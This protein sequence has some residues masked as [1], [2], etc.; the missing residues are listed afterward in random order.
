MKAEVLAVG[1][2]LLLGD[3]INTNAAEIS[4]ALAEIGV[5]VYHQSVVG[6][7]EERLAG[8]F[9]TGLA[10]SDL[11]VVCGGLGPTE[12]DLTRETLARVTG[13]DLKRNEAWAEHL[14]EIFAKRRWGKGPN[15]ELPENN[16]RQTMV[17]D[18]ATLLENTR[19]T[20]PGIYLRYNNTEVFLLP[21]PPHE[22]RGL[23]EHE[24]I[25]RLSGLL[26]ECSPEGRPP[27]LQSRVL[28]IIGLGESRVAELLR[29]VLA[30]QT[31]PTIAPLAQPGEVHLRITASGRS[32]T[33]TAPLIDK[34]ANE[35]RAVL[36]SAVYGEDDAGLEQVVGEELK[37]R[38]LSCSTA[39]SCTGGLVA[40]RLTN[41]PGSSAYF[42]G[43]AVAYSNQLKTSVLGVDAEL[44]GRDG[45]VSESVARSMAEGARNKF[46]SDVAVAITGIAGPT[47]GSEE[48]PVGLT[49]IAVADVAAT[50]CREYR[51]HGERSLVK[52]RAAQAALA[53]LRT[54]LLER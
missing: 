27:V 17:P 16:L 30:G 28:R 53:L 23:L 36:G 41:V 19:G 2:E 50:V 6:D 1:T 3:V 21:G 10:R 31:N 39:E 43:G 13:C 20:A 25:P 40:H 52:A 34:T 45:A 5:G 37:S 24:V 42:V 51:F 33:D 47:G 15:Y 12:D 35:I 14:R 54:Q 38:G 22:M 46:G 49:Y 44:I 11:L 4:R 26:S 32:K 18:G 8:A 29:D 48:K 7:N 9:E